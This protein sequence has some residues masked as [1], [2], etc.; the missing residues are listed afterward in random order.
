MH[1]RIR[2]DAR[3]ALLAA[4]V[5]V[6]GGASVYAVHAQS[7]QRKTGAAALTPLP[8][9]GSALLVEAISVQSQKV[10]TENALSGEV[11]PYRI[12]TLSSEVSQRI[13]QRPVAQG[14]AVAKGGLLAL[15]DSEQA[16]VALQQARAA[17]E[18]AA[19]ARRQAE[20]DY[21]RASVE[22]DA[23][24]QQARAQLAQAN[25]GQDQ[26]RAQVEQAKANAQKVRNFT[27][28]QELRQE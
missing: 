18:Q 19:A 27:R 14:D 22:T 8:I 6:A 11:T 4:L 1:I 2:P 13:L 16:Q 12:A 20:S 25:A 24:R 3:L 23:A 26:A 15:L 9:A 28:Q 21:A 7:R 5:V 10:Q 17:L